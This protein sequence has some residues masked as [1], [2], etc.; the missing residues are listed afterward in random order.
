MLTKNNFTKI[1]LRANGN[2]PWLFISAFYHSP[3]P[4]MHMSDN[5][6]NSRIGGLVLVL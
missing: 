3:L 4:L 5:H 2:Y 1:Q 6:K